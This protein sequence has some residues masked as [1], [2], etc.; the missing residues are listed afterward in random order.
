[1]TLVYYLLESSV[2]VEHIKFLIFVCDL[3][4][5]PPLFPLLEASRISLKPAL[6]KCG[7]LLFF[8]PFCSVLYGSFQSVNYILF[9]GKFS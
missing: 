3:Y 8:Y 1:M 2:P 6:S 9:S 5:L 7:Y 4:F